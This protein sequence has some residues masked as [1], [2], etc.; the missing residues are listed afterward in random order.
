[1]AIIERPS[2]EVA[3]PAVVAPSQALGAI[4]RPVATKGWREWL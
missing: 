1:M 3:T 4:R 2:S